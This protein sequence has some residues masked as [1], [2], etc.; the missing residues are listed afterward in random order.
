MVALRLEISVWEKVGQPVTMHHLMECNAHFDARVDFT[1]LELSCSE[2]ISEPAFLQVE[3]QLDSSRRA[4]DFFSESLLE[5]LDIR[6]QTIVF[7]FQERIVLLF[8]QRHL[9]FQL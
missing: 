4:T 2:L 8:D 6:E 9:R 5:F 7:G 1:N 3:V